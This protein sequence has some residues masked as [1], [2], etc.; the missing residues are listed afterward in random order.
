MKKITLFAVF[1]L[2][3][4]TLTAQQFHV[5]KSAEFDEPDFGWNKLLQLKNGNTFYFHSTRKDGIEV[6]VYDKQRK[7]TASQ[8]LESNLWDV[9]KMK[10]SKIVG[11]HEINGQPV[12]FVVQGDDRQPTLYRMQIN[13]NT[14]AKM[15]EA[16]LGALPK[17]GLLAGYKI[18]FGGADIPDIIVEKDPNSDCYA[19]IYFDGL[20]HDRK[21]RIKVVHYDGSNKVLTTALY[22]S[23]QGK[24]KSLRYIGAS[25]DG[26]KR[27]FIATYG[28]NGNAKDDANPAV[29]VS[30][31]NA[32]ETK[33]THSQI[34][35]SKDFNDTKSVMLYN[36]ST[37]KVV[38]MTNRI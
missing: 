10:Q 7:Q 38:L 15:G 16:K 2:H 33:F 34:K 31:V 14:G 25:V 4:C 36:H 30:K 24:Y 21:D 32:G 8:T 12:L 6:T 5:E 28:F 35:V 29:I 27:V 11:L 19:V 20:A 13:P 3:I 26:A 23:P 22:D 17:I 9:G 37:N 18:A 1:L